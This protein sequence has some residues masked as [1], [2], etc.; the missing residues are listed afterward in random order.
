MAR[1]VSLSPKGRGGVTSIFSKLLGDSVAQFASQPESSAEHQ[2]DS[3]IWWLPQDIR[4]DG[5]KLEKIGMLKK[6]VAAA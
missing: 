4:C 5:K 3:T 1:P 6:P 2:C